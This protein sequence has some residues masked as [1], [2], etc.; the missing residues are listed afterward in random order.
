MD[1][2]T[3]APKGT[4]DKLPADMNKW[5]TVE[6]VCGETAEAYGCKEI[7]TPV[8][9]HTE[10]FHRSVGDTTD[11]VQKEM[12]TFTD[13]GGRSVTL[14]PEGTAGAVRASIENGLLNGPMPLKLY[15][16]VR[17]YRYEKNQ[18][19]RFREFNQFGVE[20][21]GA[22]SPLSDAEV[23]MLAHNAITGLG[24]S[25]FKLE[26]NSIGCPK[27]RP[28]YQQ[29]LKDYYKSHEDELCGTCKERLER[30]PMRLL[31][32]KVESC[33]KFLPDAPVILDYLC[34]EC[35]EH[36]DG[37][38]TALDD[39]KLSYEI[40][41]RIVR[42]LDYYTNTVFEFISTIPGFS[43][44][45]CAGG[46]YDGLV[47]QVGGNPTCGLGFAAG[48]ERL[49][50]IM[51]AQKLEFAPAKECDIYIASTDEKSALKA[52]SLVQQLR[53]VGFWAECDISG[54][55]LRAQMKYADKIG[56]SFSMVLGETE[57]ESGKAVLKNMKDGEKLEVSI[58]GDFAAKASSLL[59]KI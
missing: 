24:I 33:R 45:I 17:C 42:G 37:V 1:L 58:D 29:A 39:M 59:I 4:S 5:H 57:L 11:V 52:F 48:L 27:C 14:R 32:C 41:G 35:R 18:K 2:L 36:F 50:M 15:Y 9:E 21:F 53:L 55:G 44:A 31:D 34:D 16:F 22:R 51:E 38:K 56:A 20:Y 3:Q 49:I 28:K 23:I 54:R 46:R 30:N 7:R 47:E 25:Q 13:N 12:Y 6:R 10:L 19:G 40:N 26:I 43:G 8:F